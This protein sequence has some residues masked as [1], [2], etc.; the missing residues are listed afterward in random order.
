MFYD[1][2]VMGMKSLSYINIK[3]FYVVFFIKFQTLY[4]SNSGLADKP[5]LI[6]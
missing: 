4:S 1:I 3:G 5:K 2:F 6:T